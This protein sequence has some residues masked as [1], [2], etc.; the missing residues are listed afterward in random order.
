MTFIVDLFVSPFQGADVVHGVDWLKKLGPVTL[1]YSALTISFVDNGQP[2]TL[3]G[4]TPAGLSI[5]SSHLRRAISTNE[6][7]E[8]FLLHITPTNNNDP[9]TIEPS[10][11]DELLME[12]SVL[13]NNPAGL[14]PPRF[15]DHLI[16][17]QPGRGPVNVRP[18][19]YP[20]FQKGEISRMITQMLHDGIIRPSRSS[21][22]S[23]VLLVRKKDGT[24]CFCVDYRV[25]N[26][27]IVRDAFP[28][29]TITSSLTN[30]TSQCFLRSW[31]SA[32]ASTKYEWSTTPSRQRRFG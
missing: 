2:I 11:I 24:W 21:F 23:L 28:I 15:T 32:P 4:D 26:S 13:L 14:P 8:L 27:V 5:C 9:P 7:C 6:I 1:D 19:R 31:T 10:M 29:P 25:L 20:H 17:L 3:Y 30:C 12:F 18:Y 22:S 16:I